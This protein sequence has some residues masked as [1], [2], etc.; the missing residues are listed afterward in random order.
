MENIVT[1]WLA[2]DRTTPE[3]GAMSVI[4]G[5]HDNGFSNYQKVDVESNIFGEEIVE[6]DESRAVT[7]QLE[8]NECSLHESRIIHGAKA[9]TS[10]NRRAGYTM[11]YFPTSS[12]II[13]E[14]N[15]GHKVW[16]VRGQDLAGNEYEN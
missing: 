10:E 1:V 12:R 7:F 13:P 14:R 4:P 15:P 5:S 9:N 11:R 8:P 16:L 3:N 2:I 6:V